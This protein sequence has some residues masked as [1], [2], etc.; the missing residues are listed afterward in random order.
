MI[1]VVTREVGG[2]PLVRAARAGTLPESWYAALPANPT[3]WTMAARHVAEEFA[4]R[5]WYTATAA[6]C[7]ARGRDAERM[8]RVAEGRG[9]VVT[10][11]QQP[12]LF[13]GPIYTW[14]KAFTALTLADEI[15]RCTGIPTAPVF[16]A[17]TDDADY[18]EASYTTVIR[19]GEVYELRLPARDSGL[20]MSALALGD[21]SAQ[22]DTLVETAGSAI[23][24]SPLEAIRDAYVP[25]QTVGGAYVTLL[26]TLLE[27][28]GIAVLDASHP[29]VRVAAAP[30][31][32]QA[33]HRAPI[34]RDAL[35]ERSRAIEGAGYRVQ[36]QP[37]SHLSLV[38]RAGADGRRSRIPVKEAAEVALAATDTE[39]G[40]NVLLRP[41]VERQIL[42]TVTYVAGPAEFAYFAQV[43]AVADALTCPRPRVVP[44][45]SGLLLEPHVRNI[46]LEVD[47]TIDDFR[48][49]HAVE[50]R[51]ARAELPPDVRDA[52]QSL[53]D[54][55]ATQATVLHNVDDDVVAPLHKAVD[56]F[57]L[58]VDHRIT[59]LERRYAAAVKRTGT[60]RLRQVALARASLFPRGVPQE[61]ALNILPFWARYGGLL[62]DKMIV[63]AASH[64]RRV[65]S[66]D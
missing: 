22:Y 27:P 33:L 56:G 46:L 30:T 28:F 37:V 15:E 11:G 31:V 41:V 59:R 66:D 45:W 5:D 13:G 62:C 44:R 4:N 8:I 65:I 17:A 20:A 26:R 58:Q 39:L 18:A 14:S 54:A 2:S 61:R 32:R 3:A 10:T 36:V 50:R 48:D 1:E 49:P 21:V 57:A 24:P 43:S 12:G 34:V 7:A 51:V 23:D 55:V 6:A 9:I 35:I 16:W 42:P 64:A 63:A 38:F 60:A 40:P 29:A 47:A 52:L 25:G 53:R 19:A